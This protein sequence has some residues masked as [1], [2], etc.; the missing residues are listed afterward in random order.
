MLTGTNVV[1]DLKLPRPPKR[2]VQAVNITN[3]L[4]CQKVEQNDVVTAQTMI[5]LSDRKR[6]A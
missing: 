4:Q 2:E 3:R 5:P 1:D 6:T